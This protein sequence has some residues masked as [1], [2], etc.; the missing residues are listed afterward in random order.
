MTSRFLKTHP[1]RERGHNMRLSAA[2]TRER[3]QTACS[4][5]GRHRVSESPNHA[6]RLAGSACDGN[7]KSG[8][9][10]HRISERLRSPAR[11]WSISRGILSLERYIAK[12]Y[13]SMQRSTSPTDQKQSKNE[14]IDVVAA[15]ISGRRNKDGGNIRGTSLSKNEHV[16]T[17]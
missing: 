8:L 11:R 12:H 1:A 3:E 10:L 2:R 15:R 7:K 14:K 5:R 6:E 4:V 16:Y 13:D 9:R 17:D